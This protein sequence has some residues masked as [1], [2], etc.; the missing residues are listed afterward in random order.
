MAPKTKSSDGGRATRPTKRTKVAVLDDASTAPSTPE[1]SVLHGDSA[2]TNQLAPSSPLTPPPSSPPLPLAPSTPFTDFRAQGEHT[3]RTVMDPSMS[4]PTYTPSNSSPIIPT[5]PTKDALQTRQTPPSSPL[6]PR[7]P[8]TLLSYKVLLPPDT[9]SAKSDNSERAGTPNGGESSPTG[10]DDATIG[11]MPLHPAVPINASAR[12]PPV[13]TGIPY[14]PE[15]TLTRLRTIATFKDVATNRYAIS[16]V[17]RSA[18]WGRQTRTEKLLCLNGKPIVMWMV[19]RVRSMWF[20]D[21]NGDPHLRVNVGVT[22][23][24]DIDR[25]A[26]VDLFNRARPASHNTP[27]DVVYAGKICSQREKGEYVQSP[28]AFSNVYDA[29]ERLTAKASMPQLSP[30][31]VV[32]N[33]IVLVECYLTRWKKA[34][35]SKGKKTWGSFDVGFELQS[36]CLLYSAPENV[37]DDDE[38]PVETDDIAVEL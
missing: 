36:L 21:R 38:L 32:K 10:G 17:P 4:I 6:D 16:T 25:A 33:D 8:S 26:V 35:D 24:F 1:Q 5:T 14:V 18:D 31:D 22:L 11:Y 29:T 28:V 2:T 3:S 20:F 12:G 7:T 13:A 27:S 30:V 34:G 9:P 23:P 37:G 19:G 15:S